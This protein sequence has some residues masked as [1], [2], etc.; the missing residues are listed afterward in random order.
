[1][2][3]ADFIKKYGKEKYEKQQEQTQDWRTTHPERALISTQKRHRK[4]GEDYEK[5]KLYGMNKLRHARE[6]IRIKHRQKWRKFKRI[7]APESQ[8]HHEWIPKTADYRGMALVE[9]N[10]HTHG[11]IDVIQ[12]LEGKIILFTEAEIRGGGRIG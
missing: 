2:N 3:K 4:D 6:L 5:T 10:Q 7:L 12:I 8:L 11:Y 1:M 9:A